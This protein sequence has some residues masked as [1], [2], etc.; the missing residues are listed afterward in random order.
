M[1][2]PLFTTTNQL[3]LA[4]MKIYILTSGVVYDYEEY[5]N[6]PKCF[7]TLEAAKKALSRVKKEFRKEYVKGSGWDCDDCERSFY[8]YPDG[9]YAQNHAYAQIREAKLA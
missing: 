9:W 4:I 7:R 5:P 6:T 2:A 8:A 3:N 1:T